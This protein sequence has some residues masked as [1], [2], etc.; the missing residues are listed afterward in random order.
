MPQG[1]SIRARLVIVEV[2]SGDVDRS[3]LSECQQ[4][5]QN[6]QLAASM[7][8]FIRWIAC[9]YD[10]LQKR[11]EARTLEIRAQGLGRTVHARLPAALAELQS[12]FEMWLEFALEAGAIST[13]ERMELEQRCEQALRELA[14][15]QARYHQASNPAMRFIGL[16]QAALASGQAH[17]ANREGAVPES[18]QLWGWRH[19]ATNGEWIAQGTR[20]GWVAGG[21]LYLEPAVS[22]QLAEALPADERLPSQQT[23]H[24]RLQESGFLA[25]VDV[26]RQMV[27]VRRTL[28]GSVRQ[29]LH[30][31]TKDLVGETP[32]AAQCQ[33][34]LEK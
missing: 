33:P 29:V 15:L 20:I 12:G 1:H 10:E 13:E 3:T 23:L 19:K 27:Q 32:A 11:I 5:G 25:S 24:R 9:R 17:V 30:L 6:G 16:L 14:V 22:Y 21:N 7:G 34:R 4:V 2:A 26:G 8:A 18:P 28:E 31:R